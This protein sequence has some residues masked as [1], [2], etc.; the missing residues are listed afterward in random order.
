[1]KVNDTYLDSSRYGT[2]AKQHVLCQEVGHTVGLDHTSEDGSDDDTCMDYA[3]ALDN[4]HT[5]D[6]DNEQ[7]N[8][9]YTAHN[10]AGTTTATTTAANGKVR[11]VRKDLYVESFPNGAKVFTFVTFTDA[12]AAA[13][14][15]NDR[16]P[17]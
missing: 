14:A 15:P 3:D 8:A 16:V 4:P 10:D 12:S 5:D 2:A 11:R 1:M 17:E 13:R 6:H 7:I 9:I